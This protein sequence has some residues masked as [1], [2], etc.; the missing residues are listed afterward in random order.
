MEFAFL[1]GALVSFLIVYSMMI[2]AAAYYKRRA[3]SYRKAAK[4]FEEWADTFHDELEQA[5]QEL[6]ELKKA[7]HDGEE[8]KYKD[9]IEEEL[10]E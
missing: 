8:W 2:G 1:T 10:S 5:K 4:Y 3:R 6:F 9:R 7:V